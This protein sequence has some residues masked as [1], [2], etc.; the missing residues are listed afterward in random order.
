MILILA[1]GGPLRGIPLKEVGEYDGRLLFIQPD[2]TRT[3]LEVASGRVVERGGA[4]PVHWRSVTDC[5]FSNSEDKTCVVP[6][7]VFRF[8]GARLAARTPQ[9]EWNAYVE[10]LQRTWS[11]RLYAVGDK[12]L[13]ESIGYRS[14]LECI[15]AMSGRSLWMYVLALDYNHGGPYCGRLVPGK[16]LPDLFEQAKFQSTVRLGASVTAPPGEAEPYAGTLVLD[17]QAETALVLARHT[18]VAGWAVLAI[19]VVV[20]VA[21]RVAARPRLMICCLIALAL[22]L[23]SFGYIDGPLLAFDALAFVATAAAAWVQ[24]E[25]SGR[26]IVGLS[27]AYTAV[28]WMLPPIVLSLVRY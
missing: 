9:G 23:L 13:I 16:A 5:P 17:P 24:S 26:V 22:H 19:V 21:A 7:G 1:G 6:A 3:V 25:R 20:A 12:L 8:D 27:V 15:D 11:Y 14:T 10:P 18:L 2:D 4:A 28:V